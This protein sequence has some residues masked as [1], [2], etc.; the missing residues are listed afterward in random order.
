MTRT[1]GDD[2]IDQKERGV[3]VCRARVAG[4]EAAAARLMVHEGWSWDSRGGS[5]AG[6][7]PRAFFPT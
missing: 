2:R 1:T 7:I 6:I 4:A 5:L 3:C